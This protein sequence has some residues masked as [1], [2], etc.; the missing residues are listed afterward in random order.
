MSE[1]SAR[2]FFALLKPRVMSLVVFTAFAG[3]MIAPGHVNP[4]LGIIAI[5]CIAVGA[6]ASGALNMWYDADIDACH[7]PH[8]NPPHSRRPHRAHRG[9]RLRPRPFGLSVMTLGLTVNWVAGGAAGLHHLLL[10]RRLHDVAEAL[11]AAEH[12]HRRCRRRLPAH[13]RLGLRDRRRERSTASLLFMIIFLWTPP[14]FWAL[15]LFKMR[16]YGN[17]PACRCCRM[18]PASA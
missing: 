6:G 3:L 2:D 12:R 16:D 14:H 11:D 9:A 4:V 8:G 10:C 17:A 5:L 18:S 1:A 13:G 15:A 7:D